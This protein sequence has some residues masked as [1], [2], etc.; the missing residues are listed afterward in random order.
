MS[1]KIIPCNMCILHSPVWQRQRQRSPQPH[2]LHYDSL[3]KRCEGAIGVVKDLPT[4]GC[5][6]CIDLLLNL[7]FRQRSEINIPIN[8]YQLPWFAVQV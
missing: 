3:D 5:T 4:R 2:D 8:D 1:Y 7:K 6:G